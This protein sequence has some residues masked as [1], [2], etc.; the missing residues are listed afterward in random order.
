LAALPRAAKRRRRELPF[1]RVEHLVDVAV[2]IEPQAGPVEL[3]DLQFVVQYRAAGRRDLIH[4][5][6]AASDAS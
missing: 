1:H 3:G 6:S 2:R 5:A 4:D